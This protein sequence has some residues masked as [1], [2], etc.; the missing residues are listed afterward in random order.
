VNLLK[1]VKD[2]LNSKFSMNDLCEAAYI[3]GTKIYRDRSKR[4]IALSQS[5][6]LE[7]ILKRFRMDQAK[8]GF[9]RMVKCTKLSVTQILAIDEDRERM[10]DIPYVSVIGSITYT[11][12]CT[13]PDVVSLTN[14]F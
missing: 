4:L 13:R 7:K 6:Y 1:S 8:K 11:M 5:M 12:M 9:F 3:V 10:S 2:Y 14:R